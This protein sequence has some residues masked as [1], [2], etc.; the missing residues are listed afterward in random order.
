MT[1]STDWRC[2]MNRLQA[3]R[4]KAVRLKT[5]RLKT[6]R[7]NHAATSWPSRHMGGAV[8]LTGVLSMILVL[9]WLHQTNAK[10]DLLASDITRLQQ[11]GRPD[12][13]AEPG[14]VQ[15]A[16]HVVEIAAV[17]AALAELAMPWEVLFKS[18]EGLKLSG[19]SVVSIEPDAKKRKVRIT[20]KAADT[21]A[22]LAY[23]E[24]LEALLMLRQVFLLTHESDPDADGLPISFDVEARWEIQ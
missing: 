2:G 17:K 4:L 20:A 18:L 16:R 5:V 9:G 23:V 21:T 11:R 12:R 1:M 8:L 6:V 22:M 10:A 14:T 19:V 15:D 13:A 3:A 7:L 24:A